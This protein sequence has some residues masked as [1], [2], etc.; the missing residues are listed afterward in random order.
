MRKAKDYEKDYEEDFID[1]VKK[2]LKSDIEKAETQSFDQTDLD[3]KANEIAFY[4]LSIN[5]I[6]Q[7]GIAR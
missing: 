7:F 2:N 3:L 1:E 5:N 6:S 4:A